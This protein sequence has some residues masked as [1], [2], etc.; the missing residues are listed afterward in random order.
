MFTIGVWLKTYPDPDEA[1]AAIQ[2]DSIYALYQKGRERINERI[3]STKILHSA[4]T[5]HLLQM[6]NVFYRS[7]IVDGIKGFF[8]LYYPEFAAQEIHITADY[9]QSATP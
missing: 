1:V 8:K 5:G 6:E 3:K 4:I 9:L 7:T 2:K